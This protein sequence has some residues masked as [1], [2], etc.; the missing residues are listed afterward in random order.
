MIDTIQVFGALGLTRPKELVEQ[1][2]LLFSRMHKNSVQVLSAEASDAIADMI[3]RFEL[4]LDYLSNQS[5]NEEFL[6]QTQTQLNRANLLLN[7]LI[8]TPLTAAEVVAPTKHFG[9]NT[10]IYD[11]EGERI[12]SDIESPTQALATAAEA[13]NTQT[14]GVQESQALA[15]ARQALKDLSLI[16]I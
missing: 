6:D 14:A 3:A 8:E 7:R 13:P 1:I 2:R 12:A 9:R 15:A 11:D 4:F 16:H 10:L 5:I